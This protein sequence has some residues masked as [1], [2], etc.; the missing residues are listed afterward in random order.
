[1]LMYPKLTSSSK[2]D[3]RNASRLK[4]EKISRNDVDDE[5]KQE[6]VGE[7]KELKELKLLQM[8]LEKYTKSLQALVDEMPRKYEF[9]DNK[10]LQEQEQGKRYQ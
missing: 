6:I 8:D 3:S 9:N 1:M 10:L 4:D 2:L 7:K 5:K